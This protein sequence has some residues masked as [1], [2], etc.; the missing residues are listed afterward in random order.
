[1]TRIITTLLYLT[2]IF[3]TAGSQYRTTATINWIG[4]SSGRPAFTGQNSSSVNGLL[5][6]MTHRF[7]GLLYN[8]ATCTFDGY[9]EL[10]A[11]ERTYIK[12][13]GIEE[14]D[15]VDSHTTYVEKTPIL[16]VTVIPIVFD[17]LDGRYKKATQYT[18]ELSNKQETAMKIKAAATAFKNE[19]VLNSGKWIRIRV[20]HTGIHS[21][22]H[23]TLRQWGFNDP[24]MVAIYGNGGQMLPTYNSA[25]RHDDLTP[26]A[27]IHHNS[28]ILFYARGADGYQYDAN[29]DLF[30]Y[31]TH[32]YETYAYYFITEQAEHPSPAEK[33]YR[34]L[35]ATEAITSFNDMAHHE[36]NQYNLLRSGQQWFGERFDSYT[37]MRSFSFSFPQ[38]DQTKEINIK[39]SAA[40]R[41]SSTS[42]F[43]VTFNNEYLDEISIYS[44]PLYSEE[45]M[46]A[47][48]N[49]ISHQKLMNQND[50]TLG[51]NFSSGF[52]N[53]LGWLDYITINA[54][55][56]LIMT[57]AQQSF[58]STRTITAQTAVRFM[59]ENA[60]ENT[61]VWD[62][63]SPSS[64]ERVLGDL[65]EGILAF[66]MPTGSLRE[67]IAFDPNG[68][69]PEPTLQETV[70]NQNLHALQPV[71]FI[72]L[73]HPNFYSQAQRLAESHMQKQNLSV[74]IVTPQQIYNEFSSGSRDITA[75][76]DF[77]RML[78]KRADTKDHNRL[79]Y[80]LLF[81]DGSYNNKADEADNPNF[82][83]T[84]QSANSLHQ[85]YSYVSDDIY[86]YLDDEEGVNETRDRLDI[87]IGRFPVQTVQ[88]AQYA[89]DKSIRHMEGGTAGSWKKTLAFVG[90]DGDSNIHMLQ[91]NDLTKVI[92]QRNPEFDIT[93]IYLDSYIPTVSSS[94][95]TYPDANT[96]INRAIN[97][98]ALIFNY[99]GH[100]SSKALSHESVVTL[101]SIQSW[102]NANKLALFVTATCQF[103]R[104]DERS[105]TSAGE[106]T[107]LNPWGGAIALFTTTRIAYSNNNST[108]NTA[109]F[110]YAFQ[111]DTEGNKYSMG[112]I[113]QKTK[114]ATGTNSYKMSFTLIGDPALPLQNPENNIT[115]DS[116]NG[117]AIEAFDQ[118]LTAMSS[119]TISGSI[120][121]NQGFVLSNFNGTVTIT[122][123]DKPLSIKTRGNVGT[124][125][126]YSAYQSVIFK[127]SAKVTNGRFSTSFIVPKD[128]R[129]NIGSGRISYY[130]HDEANKVEASG[131]NNNIQIGGVSGNPVNDTTG[132]KVKLWLNNQSFKNGQKVGTSPLLLAH[133]NDDSGINTT[134]IG[135]GHDITLFIDDDRSSPIILNSYYE[136]DMLDF[137]NGTLTYQLSKLTT[138]KHTLEL[139]VWDNMNNSSTASINF[140]VVGS[141]GISINSSVLYPNPCSISQDQ[142]KLV[143]DHDEYNATLKMNIRI[144][145]LTGQLIRQQQE[146]V[147]AEGNSISPIVVNTS[148]IQ[149]GLYLLDV[150][151]SSTNG[152]EGT[153]S[154]KIMFIQ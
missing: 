13:A 65:N 78:Y 128:I 81:G 73:T 86:G 25:D 52:T 60:T 152:R 38:L 83:P 34:S 35:T 146:H 31:Q 46:F 72:I 91:A 43:D 63:T 41:S 6:A 139:R 97:D 138:G 80:L 93:K 7:D 62:V 20:D 111:R 53:A 3:F 56:K 132:P 37:P 75:I 149:P 98:G 61:I 4:D 101:A 116:I 5:P 1:M 48:E 50:I 85:S 70:V 87:G 92:A 39:V 14:I 58:R 54:H 2:S 96:D 9:K 122:I 140:E 119:N 120:R 44:V 112:E 21:I 108:I 123:F 124:P 131:A 126:T 94:G 33:D 36:V 109:L 23:T 148:N 153:F 42:R 66:N 49:S 115:T 18:I 110:D 127:G 17:S 30:E 144:F 32:Q 59:L 67:L 84:Y 16:E 103:T 27:I 133:I 135:I 114:N 89:V 118:S 134:G 113:I 121:N 125:F 107:F 77:L 11:E 71:N 106:Q 22:S 57:A 95:T 90:D 51:L 19:S 10:T 142:L 130:A 79:K 100:G 136:T 105:E 40:A 143:F 45:Y 102:N 47:N 68:S 88:Q 26:C 147:T 151:I 82:I 55:S 117:I 141:K 29:T 15:A 129:Y 69:F 150:K 28:S 137:T 104:Y 12:S 99:T 74:A 8:Q 76:R 24:A 64:P 145:N 154:K